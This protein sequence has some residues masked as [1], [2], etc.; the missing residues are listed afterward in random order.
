MASLIENAITKVATVTNVDMKTAGAAALYSV[1]A[2]KTFYPYAVAVR[3]NSD[4][5]AG[6]TDYDFTGWRQ[7]VDLSGLTV[8]TGFRYINS[9][10]NTTYTPVSGGSDFEIT[11]NTG[12]TLD[13]TC[14]IDIFGY[15]T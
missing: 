5:L 3:N 14:T 2:G 6:G 4:S 8:T 10:D 1:P 13:A 11:V 7:T 9:E 12:S 15:L